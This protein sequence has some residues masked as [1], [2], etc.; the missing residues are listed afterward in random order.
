MGYS[1]VIIN[2]V[3]KLDLTEDTVTPEKLLSGVTAHNASGNKV[4][5][6]IQNQNGDA[7]E[8][9]DDGDILIPS[10]YYPS[11]VIYTPER[12]SL[13][14]ISLVTYNEAPSEVG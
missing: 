12:Q 9:N 13:G 14:F 1:K 10:G 2:G 5:G 3:T 4:V 7:I 11:Q 8:E 6:S